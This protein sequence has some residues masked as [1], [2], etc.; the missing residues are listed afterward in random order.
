MPSIFEVC[1]KSIMTLIT[2]NKIRIGFVVL[3]FALICLSLNKNVVAAPA[4]TLVATDA[5][6]AKGVKEKDVLV[7]RGLPYAASP[8][9][10]LRWRAPQPT[11]PWKG[12][13][14]AN[15]FGPICTQPVSPK[16]WTDSQAMS[17]DC[18][19]LNVFRPAGNSQQ[20]PVLFWIPGGGLLTGSGSRP[21][22][23]GKALAHK[24]LVVVT[25]NYRLGHFG[26]F[27]H[28]DLTKE[29]ADDGRLFN[30][31]LMDQIAALHWVQNNIARF[32]G[33]P[34][35]VTIFG[36]SAGGA[37]VDLLMIAPDAR[38]LFA[39]AIAQSGYGRGSFPRLTTVS[40][41]GDAPAESIG[42]NIARKLGIPNASLNDLRAIAA[43]RIIALAEPDEEHIFAVDGKTVLSDL[44]PAFARNEEAPVPFIIGSNS[45]EMGALPADSQRPWAEKNVPATRWTEL[46]PFYANAADRDHLILSDLI[47]T[48][49]A[50]AL[51][52]RH[53]ANGHPTYLY[54]FD[55]PT[56]T[57]EGLL[58]GAEH[59]S[60]IA[61]V[62][63]NPLRYSKMSVEQHRASF[64]MM[65]YWTNMARKGDPNGPGLPVWKPYD[66]N[67]LLRIGL[68]QTVMK[69]DP[70]KERLDT[71][72][73]VSTDMQ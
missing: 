39:S 33:D 11:V 30:Y 60:E 18:L 27:A 25:I 68:D 4:Q 48:S 32:G 44:W 70:L 49:Q 62:F 63:G 22:F 26:F 73:R 19:Y 67:A 2:G 51:A 12:V 34:A 6:L 61:Y 46:T 57:E 45:F 16:P 42:T 53:A 72:D 24:G 21:E 69:A 59:A 47:F 8:Q 50:R 38:G 15:R 10:A 56:R 9:G 20:L 23:D 40:A 1:N 65:S 13:R 31:G 29:N 17:E 3:L 28:P 14:S 66:G 52:Q 37:S 36:E 43:E 41:D 35:K 71:L 5:G 7:F 58:P 54:R 64:E 55:I